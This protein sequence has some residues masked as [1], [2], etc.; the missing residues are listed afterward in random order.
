MEKKHLWAIIGMLG[1]VWLYTEV[2]NNLSN[3]AVDDNNSEAIIH[4]YDSTNSLTTNS[5]SIY[6]G[7]RCDECGK[8]CKR[9]LELHSSGDAMSNYKP[10]YL[11]GNAECTNNRHQK[12]LKMQRID[13]QEQIYRSN[14]RMNDP[15]G[16]E[17]REKVGDWMNSL[18]E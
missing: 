1:V 15:Q 6:S 2:K 11:C 12:D 13:R 17:A 14:E 9:G 10:Y 3:S 16:E 5:E 18:Q 7:N 8:E 4:D